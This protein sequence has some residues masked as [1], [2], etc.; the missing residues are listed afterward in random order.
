MI[1]LPEGVALY[2]LA[3][4]VPAKGII[5]EIGCYGGLSTAFLLA[6]AGKGTIIHSIDPFRRNIKKQKK[7]VEEYADT[8]YKKVELP[9][10]SIKPTKNFVEESLRRKG[11]TN[12]V[13]LE[14]YSHEFVK[15]WD[16]QIDLLWI[17]GNHDYKAVKN[18]FFKWSVF[19][20][21]GGIIAFHDANKENLSQ[22]WNWGCEGPTRIVNEYIKEP[23][24]IDIKRIDA[25]VY[26]TKNF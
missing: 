2:K 9:I 12:F 25:L 11:F 20:K 22:F 5:V 7:L 6:G 23:K 13:L 21:K 18:D 14:G 1:S 24:W 19:L 17:D 26:A 3:N 10:V 4:S 16:K 15:K 8:N